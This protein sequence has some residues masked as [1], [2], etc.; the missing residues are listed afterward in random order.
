ME[1]SPSKCIDTASVYE[2]LYAL[3]ISLPATLQSGLPLSGAVSSLGAL[4]TDLC[5]T[6]NILTHS[7]PR[8]HANA[9]PS[10]RSERTKRT[11]KHTHAQNALQNAIVH[12]TSRLLARN[13]MQH[14]T[15]VEIGKRGQ[16]ERGSCERSWRWRKVM[17]GQVEALCR[18]ESDGRWRASARDQW[19]K[20]GTAGCGAN[21]VSVRIG[22]PAQF[23]KPGQYQPSVPVVPVI[24]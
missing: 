21:P 4:A 15:E 10:D 8:S 19:I 6:A 14:N 13:R 5:T 24:S 1:V 17:E 7:L 23:P 3:T 9:T 22:A 11:P 20:W 2:F 16:E 12:Q 18:P